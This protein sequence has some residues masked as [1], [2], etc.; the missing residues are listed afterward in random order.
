[1]SH[2]ASND[3][4]ALR[5]AATHPV[6]YVGLLGPPARRDE[7]LRPLDAPARTALIRARQ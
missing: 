5:A 3:P 7:L 4:E 6:R 2:T 1:M